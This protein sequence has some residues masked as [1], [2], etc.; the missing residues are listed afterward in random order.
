VAKSLLNQVQLLRQ[1]V[2]VIVKSE[3]IHSEM[4]TP[5]AFLRTVQRGYKQLSKGHVQKLMGVKSVLQVHTPK[6]VVVQFATIVIVC[7]AR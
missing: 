6:E 2:V 7:L 4:T 5:I 1:M 3:H